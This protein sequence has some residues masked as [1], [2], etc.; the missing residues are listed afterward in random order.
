MN[1]KNV[2]LKTM[3]AL[4]AVAFG[5]MSCNNDDDNNNNPQPQQNVLQLA[6]ANPNLDVLEAAATRA[7]AAVTNVLSGT[8]QITV[9]APTDDAF[10]RY[11]GVANEAA[12]ITAINGLAPAAVADILTYHVISGQA[13][14]AANVPAGPNAEVTTVRANN[15]RAYVTRAA[16]GVSIN[17]SRVVNADVAAS[18]GVVHVIDAVLYPPVGNIVQTAT[19]ELYAA[20][21]NIL[22]AAVTRAGLADALSG[23]G[24]FTVFAPTDDALLATLRT[25]L[26]NPSLTE[27]EALSAIP[28]LTDT[29]TPLNVPALRNILLYHVA[30]GRNYSAL[31]TAGN[32]PTL[33]STTGGMVQ[34][35]GTARTVAVALPASGVTVTGGGN[36]GTASNVVG[37]F[38]NITTTNGVIHVIDRVLLPGS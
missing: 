35:G 21:F 16:G 33:L 1:F 22:V 37:R 23:T 6:V 7:G 29:S 30:S 38:A 11:L 3:A 12:A 31:L 18:N 25:V 36:G 32:V 27:A 17:G 19:N 4:M 26:N 15:N 14:T 9:F 13:I 34:A 24:P 5:A 8:T 2:N 28:T 10:V 20:N